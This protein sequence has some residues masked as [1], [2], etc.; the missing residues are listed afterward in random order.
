[1]FVPLP[2]LCSFVYLYGWYKL[3][4]H[5]CPLLYAGYSRLT[6]R[7]RFEWD[8][9]VMCMAHCTLTSAGIL[10]SLL[11]EPKELDLFSSGDVLVPR[12]RRTWLTFTL[13]YV[14]IDLFVMLSNA[15]HM[16]VAE[17]SLATVHH[18]IV[19]FAHSLSLYLGFATWYCAAFQLLEWGNISM[20]LNWFFGVARA[21]AS[22]AYLIN[23]VTMIFTYVG[24]RV[25]WTGYVQYLLY[26]DWT[27]GRFPD[28]CSSCDTLFVISWVFSALQFYF[29]FLVL[30]G[31]FS[32]FSGGNDSPTATAT[33]TGVAANGK[34]AAPL[35]SARGRR[36]DITL[37]RSSPSPSPSSSSP[38]RPII[39]VS[40]PW[41]VHDRASVAR[42]RGI[43]WL[44]HEFN[45]ELSAHAF[46]R[47]LGF[48]KVAVFIALLF[49]GLV[50]V[51]F[52]L[53][54][55]VALFSLSIVYPLLSSLQ[56][57][58]HFLRHYRTSDVVHLLSYWVVALI[59][60]LVEQYI[61]VPYASDMLASTAY[62]LAKY[63]YVCAL[64]F[65]NQVLSLRL[66]ALV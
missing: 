40:N 6:D 15:R 57:V 60:Y 20:H 8:N 61:L 46:L 7:Q 65:P 30:R 66:L 55:R 45:Y 23:G 16:S 42:R 11:T 34:L 22:L 41:T 36:P 1:M 33:A 26:V 31:A 9:R 43:H 39:Q 18:L 38:P 47:P 53:R 29:T 19:L 52:N 51:A 17:L 13:T 62:S 24:L 2:I 27:D 37:T 10:Y 21:S 63:F 44:Y 4:R 59:S 35:T 28:E 32:F 25:V 12:A 49:S 58:R 48:M 54:A 56:A 50:A 14:L 5:V 3:S 64:L